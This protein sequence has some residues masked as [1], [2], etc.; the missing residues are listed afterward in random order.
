MKRKDKDIVTRNLN[1][2]FQLE[3]DD[4]EDEEQLTLAEA[5]VTAKTYLHCSQTGEKEE[6]HRNTARALKLMSEALVVSAP[7]KSPTRRRTRKASP[8]GDPS[9]PDDDDNDEGDYCRGRDHDDHNK[10]RR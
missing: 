6:A 9:S 8:G 1:D 2:T 5:L 7:K 4:Y 3:D 10:N